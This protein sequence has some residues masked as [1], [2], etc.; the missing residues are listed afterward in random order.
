MKIACDAD[1]LIK[2]VKAG[3]LEAFGHQ[4]DILVGPQVYRE[5]VEEGKDLG[6]P[7]AFELERLLKE[8][9][10]VRRT[11][12]GARTPVERL[13]KGLMLG[14]GERETMRLYFLE[15]AEA[16]LSDDRRFLSVLQAQGIPYLTP[17]ASLILLSEQGALSP[18]EA[19]A[20][21]EK[22]RAFIR[23]DQYEKAYQ[24]LKTSEERSR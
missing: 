5:A 13:I 20:A 2:M 22:L 9:A 4:V 24:D 3:I 14:A 1:G 15:R 8:H 10:Q 19:Q 6:Y 7:D 23:R 11:M 12:P 21:L 16:V 17:A 18:E